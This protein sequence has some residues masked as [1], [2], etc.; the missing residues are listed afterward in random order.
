[1]VYGEGLIELSATPK[2]PPTIIGGQ[3]NCSEGQRGLGLTAVGLPGGGESLHE[4]LLLGCRMVSQAS[5]EGL[6]IYTFKSRLG[7]DKSAAGVF[8]DIRKAL[9]YPGDRRARQ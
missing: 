8:A 6:S 5:G 4:G 9:I 2:P 1:M 3:V 7:W